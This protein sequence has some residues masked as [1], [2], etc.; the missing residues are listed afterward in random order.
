MKPVVG[1]RREDKSPWERRVPIIPQDA[2][3][4]QEGHGLRVIVQS[5][6]I[7]VFGDGEYEAARV[8]V[9]DDL[10]SAST[11][12]AV[13]EVPVDLLE[14]DKAYVFFAHVIKGQSYN[15]PMLKRMMELRCSLIDYERVTDEKNRRL[16]F[17]GRHAG[18]AGMIDTLWAFGQR[19]ACEGLPTPFTKIQQTHRYEN[20]DQALLTLDEVKQSITS[21][22]LPEAVSPLIVGI[23]GY[24]NVSLGAQEILDHL[25]ATEIRPEDIAGVVKSTDASRHVLY[26]AVFREEHM[27]EPI[28]P[29]QGFELHDYYSHPEK[30]RSAFEK[31][32]PHLSILINA[33]YWDTMYPRLVTKAYVWRAY[34]GDRSPRLKVIGDISCDIDGAV[35]VTVKATEPGDPVF[36]Y[37]PQTGEARNGFE[38][39]G[40]V[41]MAVDI[42]PTELPRESSVDFSRIL[43]KY[44]PAIATADFAVPFDHL[45]LPPEIKRGVILYHGKLTPDYRYLAGFLTPGPNTQ[46]EG[47]KG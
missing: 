31:Y 15:M 21:R 26:K 44:V 39:Q 25:P 13:K 41:I 35:E 34:R 27:V 46:R 45:D 37:D 42:L 14:P 5:S 11:I 6:G 29:H 16:I 18:L 40:P 20:L 19:L 2:R 24:G 4:L 9:Q 32:L 38:G 28:R 33:I 22:G 23:A 30:Y 12:F 3:E 17:F 43:R 8:A 47:E 36:V 10:S 1:I 7:R